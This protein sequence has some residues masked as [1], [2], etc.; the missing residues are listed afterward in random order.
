MRTGS[1]ARGLEE[2]LDLGAVLGAESSLA[3]AAVKAGAVGWE[4][5]VDAVRLA[6]SD[7]GDDA[8]DALPGRLHVVEPAPLVRDGDELMKLP[9]VTE[10]EVGRVVDHGGAAFARRLEQMVMMPICMAPVNFLVPARQ[11]TV[12]DRGAS[13]ERASRISLA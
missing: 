2:V 8:G 7:L 12:V 9:R 1:G 3:A 6:G 10:A 11:Q 13:A 4:R 5:R